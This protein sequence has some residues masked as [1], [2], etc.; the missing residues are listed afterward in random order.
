MEVQPWM[1]NGVK[2]IDNPISEQ[3]AKDLLE[4]LREKV[5]D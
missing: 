5:V 4:K 1:N 3:Y 2:T